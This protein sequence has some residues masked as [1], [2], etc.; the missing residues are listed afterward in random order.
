MKKLLATTAALALFA[1]P[2]L[3]QS[4]DP[5][6]TTP[7]GEQS[8]MSA[9]GASG[10]DISAED[11]V[12]SQDR[13]RSVLETAGMS[14][15]TILDA[16]YIVQATTPDGE[17]VVMIIDTSGRVMG[18]QATPTAPGAE[19]GDQMSTDDESGDDGSMDADSDDDTEMDGEADD[20]GESDAD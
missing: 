15:V 20:S 8:E 4:D 3:A 5:D 1:S 19:S 13:V 6:T 18:A 17:T 16:A 9:D 11:V 14:D 12:A 2:V 7:E 10:G